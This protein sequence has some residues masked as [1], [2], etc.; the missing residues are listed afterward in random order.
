M[1]IWSS[2]EWGEWKKKCVP[3]E[4]IG[5]NVFKAKCLETRILSRD[6]P[7]YGPD[8]TSQGLKQTEEFL[9]SRSTIAKCL[10]LYEAAT[11]WGRWN[12][13]H[14]LPMVG[15]LLLFSSYLGNSGRQQV[16]GR[17]DQDVGGS[18][19]DP[20]LKHSGSAP[21]SSGILSMLENNR[22]R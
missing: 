18:Q 3:V 14:Q 16:L 9:R 13:S 19:A 6:N 21:T 7:P 2:Q 12:V 11:E 5:L 4:Q 10:N 8:T 15:S 22:G 17:L 20:L 1:P